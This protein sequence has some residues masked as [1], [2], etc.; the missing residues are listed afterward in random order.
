ME[1]VLASHNRGKL[2]EMQQLLAPL[3]ATVKLPEDLGIDLEPEETGETF[4]ENSRIKAE[5]YFAVCGGAAVIADDSGLM[6]DAL[7]G[8]PGVRSARYGAPECRTDADRN[9]HLLEALR[10]V[11]EGERGAQFVCA[12]TCI[13]P[14]GT[15]LTAE[16]VCRGTI[17][18]ALQGE[19][20][21][22]YDPLFYVPQ[23]GRSYAE[24]LPEEKNRISHRARAFAEL[25]A[26]LEAFQEV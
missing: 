1:F 24:L 17:L 13:L 10:D 25:K 14:D 23:L 2:R 19:G 5:A 12:A 7:G 6:V 15:V 26:R 3:G 22:G 11:P 18:T 9:A 21:F 4:R 8:A 16:G 20:G